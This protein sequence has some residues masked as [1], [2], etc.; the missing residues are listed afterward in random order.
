MSRRVAPYVRVSTADQTTENQD[1]ELTAIA[2]PM[3]WEIVSICR[4]EGISGW[5]LDLQKSHQLQ[6]ADQRPR[7]GN[8]LTSAKRRDSGIEFPS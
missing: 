1:R 6:Y 7:S 2:T 5:S 4:D 8:Y 3:G